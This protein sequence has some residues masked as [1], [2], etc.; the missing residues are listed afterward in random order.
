MITSTTYCELEPIAALST[1]ETHE[2]DSEVDAFV[3]N[4]IYQAA[5][6]L[7]RVTSSIFDELFE[8]TPSP[9]EATSTKKVEIFNH[10][11]KMTF[12]SVKCVK[13]C[14][15]SHKLVERKTVE[16]FNTIL[17][18]KSFKK[19]PRAHVNPICIESYSTED[20][21][22]GFISKTYEQLLESLKTIF[23]QNSSSR[24]KLQAYARLYTLK[25]PLRSD[26]HFLINQ[27]KKEFF[28]LLPKAFQEDV[29]FSIWMQCDAPD[30]GGSDF[31]GE[32]FRHNV[33]T[34]VVQRSVLQ[35]AQLPQLFFDEIT[36]SLDKQIEI[37]IKTAES[38]LY[39][40]PKRSLP[41]FL[42][43]Y[44]LMA[45]DPEKYSTVFLRLFLNFFSPDD[46]K[47]FVEIFLKKNSSF[48]LPEVFQ[49][50]KDHPFDPKVYQAFGVMKHLF[51]TYLM[52]RS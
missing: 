6:S 21:P 46:Q 38:F 48:T 26:I 50:L 17:L 29:K 19:Y 8:Q 4:V 11:L 18:P 34:H 42:Q 14:F 30:S 45:Q 51:S 3:E 12:S 27:A 49:L 1:P 20:N 47:T 10:D 25:I 15:L 36:E 24:V 52:M 41:L 9:F 33:A 28:P 40:Q 2:E 22:H 5:A 43:T 32:Y 31:G 13:D 16:Q 35:N 7:Q 37:L 39:C 23:T 44:Q